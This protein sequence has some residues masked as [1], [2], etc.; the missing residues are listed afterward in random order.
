[1]KKQHNLRTGEK[2][3]IT[4]LALLIILGLFNATSCKSPEKFKFD[5][6]KFNIASIF[7]K[8]SR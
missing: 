8:G 7:Q 4:T 1:M 5:K 3:I 2:I 6:P